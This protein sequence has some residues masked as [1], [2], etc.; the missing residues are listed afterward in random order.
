MKLTIIYDDKS[1]GKDGVFYDSLDF[2]SVA[3]PNDF[4]AL[5]W[6][7]SNGHIEYSDI[8]TQNE[9]ITALPEWAN[10]CLTLWQNAY[11]AHQAE[12]AA[13]K[14]AAEAAAAEAAAA[15]AASE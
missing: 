4:W 10:S 13:A 14:A 15:E 11:D 3:F 5:Q 2:S 12:I 9:S 1:V 6:D 8:M 7:G